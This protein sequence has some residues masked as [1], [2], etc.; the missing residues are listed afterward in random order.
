MTI[1]ETPLDA[2]IQAIGS[3]V[4]A[5]GDY[6]MPIPGL[7]FYRREQPASPVVCMVEPCIVLVAQGAKQL[8][9]G[10]E[11]YPYDT[12]RFLVT[13]LDI[14]A[15]SEVLVASPE[16]PCL[17][18][19]FKLDLRILA[20]QIAQSEL[21]PARERS[22]LKGVGI[23]TVTQGMLASF[24]R[25]V[26]LL[27]EP[28]AIAVLAPLIQREIHYRLLK[29]DQASRLRQIC[30][31]D[32]QG[33]RIAKAID[34]LKLNYDAALRVD[35][36]AARVQM[37][38]ATFH[39]HFRQLTAMS[40][41]QYQKWLRLNEARRL[42]LNEHQ[43]VSSAAFKVG[44]ESPSQFSREYS[45]L[46]GMPPKRDVAALRGKATVSDQPP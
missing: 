42:M 29:S 3:R 27:D 17:G 43:D 32:G 14:P 1:N 8:W 34:W 6:P 7:G 39:H 15:N 25:L 12:S 4:Q 19:T 38:A 20:E 10:G 11:G 30:S 45:R 9:A 41:L 37:S 28:E 36:L 16:R 35:E 13:S 26:A 5:P 24:A 21:P 33:Y 31:V 40:P 2:L 23:G 46:F 18:L 44:Y 22:V